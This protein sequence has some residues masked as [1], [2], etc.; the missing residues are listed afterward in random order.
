VPRPS[1][2]E[3]DP[4]GPKLVRRLAAAVWRLYQYSE[5]GMLNTGQLRH[6]LT[7]AQFHWLAGRAADLAA[8]VRVAS[9]SERQT[10]RCL[11][12]DPA[13]TVLVPTATGYQQCGNC[14]DEPLDDIWARIPEQS[15]IIANKAG[16]LS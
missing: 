2:P 6:R 1:V 9:S 7:G 13:G 11:I 4:T 10:A 12:V 3:T 14:L 16:Y 5:R 8:P 15:T